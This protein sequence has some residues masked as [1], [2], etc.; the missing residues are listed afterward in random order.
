MDDA[1]PAATRHRRRWPWVVITLVIAIAAGSWYWGASRKQDAQAI[2]RPTHQK[3][4]S[5]T[6]FRGAENRL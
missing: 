3:L 5:E 4:V 6:T 1:F 2:T